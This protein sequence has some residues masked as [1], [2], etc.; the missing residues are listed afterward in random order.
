MSA[1]VL[2]VVQAYSGY[3]FSINTVAYQKLE[4]G[5]KAKLGTLTFV[6]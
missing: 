2:D 4:Y 1:V 3:V 5:E 6:S